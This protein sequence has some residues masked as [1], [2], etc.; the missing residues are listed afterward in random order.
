MQKPPEQPQFPQTNANVTPDG[1]VVNIMLAPNIQITYGLSNEM[2]DEIHL[3]SKEARKQA[4][5]N[6]EVVRNM[7]VV[8]SI[9]S[10]RG[11]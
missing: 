5:A 3:K 10:K 1:V 11:S 6:L 8:R 2:L 7:D 4:K 9:N